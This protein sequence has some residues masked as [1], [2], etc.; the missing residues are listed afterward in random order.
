MGR[1]KKFI[2]GTKVISISIDSDALEIIEDQCKKLNKTRS[3]FISDILITFAFSKSA[4]C[5]M[6]ARKAAQDLYYWKS[7][8]EA[9]E[10]E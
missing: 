4:F 2:N 7:R 6:K 9:L 3:D 5:D 10:K 8:K 1:K